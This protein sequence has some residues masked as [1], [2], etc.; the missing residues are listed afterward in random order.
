[1]PSKLILHRQKQN[2][3]AG[4]NHDWTHKETNVSEEDKLFEFFSNKRKL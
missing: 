4:R 1:M 2:K 3:P